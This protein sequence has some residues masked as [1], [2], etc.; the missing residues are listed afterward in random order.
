MRRNDVDWFVPGVPI[1]VTLHTG[2]YF[3]TKYW[4]RTARSIEI[5]EDDG[6]YSIGLRRVA[7][8]RQL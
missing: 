3:D 4:N 1:R 7:T 2:E 5:K 8:V 6:I